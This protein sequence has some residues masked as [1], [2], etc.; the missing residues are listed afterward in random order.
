MCVD[1]GPVQ[2]ILSPLFFPTL[3]RSSYIVSAGQEHSSLAEA[4]ECRCFFDLIS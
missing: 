3:S 4:G 1:G 2:Q